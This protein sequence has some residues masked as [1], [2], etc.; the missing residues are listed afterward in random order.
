M[1]HSM[2]QV[3]TGYGLAS[4]VLL[5]ALM[6]PAY[7]H[8]HADGDA[9][10]SHTQADGVHHHHHAVG[11]PHHDH[12]MSHGQSNSQGPA[13]VSAAVA[14]EHFSFLFFEVTWPCRSGGSPSHH[15]DHNGDM[16]GVIGQKVKAPVDRLVGKWKAG[17]LAIALPCRAPSLDARTH[18]RQVADWPGVESYLCDTARHERSGVQLL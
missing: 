3:V 1:P 10:H 17:E 2:L 12:A 15:D 16:P 13:V 5:L 7:H 4:A 14:H 18:S 6:P 11:G 8:A 9:S